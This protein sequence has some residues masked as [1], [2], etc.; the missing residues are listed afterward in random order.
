M[1]QEFITEA[2]DSNL[3]FKMSLLF[4]PLFVLNINAYAQLLF[5]SE[6]IRQ[7]YEILPDETKAKI[8]TYSSSQSGTYYF[9]TQLNRSKETIIFRINTY[10]E[11]EHLGLYLINDSIGSPSLRDVFD[12]LE[13]EF[14]VSELTGDPY[15]L[16]VESKLTKTEVFYNGLSYKNSNSRKT[17]PKI[18]ID[19]RTP[20]KLTFD[21]NWFLIEWTIDSL[22]K[23]QVK[24]PN[25][26]S[27]ITGKTKDELEKDMLR[28][29]RYSSTGGPFTFRPEKEQLKSYKANIYIYP[30]EIYQDVP[31]M[32]TKKFFLLNDTIVPVFISRYY[33][34]SIRNLFMNLVPTSLS[35][36]INQKLYG[37]NSENL[38]ININSFF[39]NFSRDF[40]IYFAWENISR[41][42]LKAGI[43]I[44]NTLYNYN[45]LLEISSNSEAVFNKTDNIKGAFY[46][47][48]PRENLNENFKSFKKQ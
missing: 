39:S 21:Q 22:K 1:K 40:S 33:T 18:P 3:V 12:Y 24:I 25:D 13:R 38:T 7:I 45:H 42:S 36:D 23:F 14:L 4:I 2:G 17:F 41:D 37:G 34:E 20:F 27:L 11:L 10:K 28:D 32:S 47:F 35:M 48:I 26:Y 31:E 16:S 8:K 29:L 46:A 19:N 44:S 15:P 5:N 9:G 30:G 6:R 43:I